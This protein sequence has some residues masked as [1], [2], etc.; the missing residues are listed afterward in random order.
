[1]VVVIDA[2]V[3]CRGLTAGSSHHNLNGEAHS[4]LPYSRGLSRRN[5]RRGRIINSASRRRRK[6][7]KLSRLRR[8]WNS[9]SAAEKL[10]G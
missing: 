7:L 10:F 6:K 3:T 8:K 4:A 5:R 1:M 2:Y 9:H